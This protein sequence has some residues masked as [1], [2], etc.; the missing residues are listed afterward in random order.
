[1]TTL[2]RTPVERDRHR[3]GHATT[4]GLA[5]LLLGLLLPAA[6]AE[7]Q[8]MGGNWNQMFQPPISTRDA[9]LMQRMV[10]LDDS[11]HELVTSFVEDS[12]R[13]FQEAAEK[14][15]RMMQA[16]TEEFQ[17][18]RDPKVWQD[19]MKKFVGFEERR[20]EI[21]QDF[22]EEAKLVLTDEQLE[23]F[24]R[25]ER[26]HFRSQNLQIQGPARV[27]A[28]AVDLVVVVE[29]ME[30]DEATAESMC[31]LLDGYARESDGELRKVKKLEE[32]QRDQ[33][34]AIMEDGDW[35]GQMDEMNALFSDMRDQLVRVRDVNLRYARQVATR[36][37]TD[38]QRG[39]F[40]RS[41]NRTAYPAIFKDSYVDAAFRTV[42]ESDELNEQERETVLRLRN[43]FDRA[44]WLAN[45]RLADAQM[46]AD[47]KRT[48]QQMW[49]QGGTPEEVAEATRKKS[50]LEESYYGQLRDALRPELRKTLAPERAKE[51][52]DW[53]NSDF[54]F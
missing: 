42:L 19:M 34:L 17:E 38:Q 3:S 44:A 7:A 35:L 20:E 49:G 31:D 52:N 16:A 51:E 24:P 14:M 2:T 13:R 48:M 47:E 45:S 4:L 11:Q 8:M 53:R 39:D 30:R 1:M 15:H 29:E 5:L 27:D 21:A 36:M 18:S 23:R 40:E 43:D 12:T 6:P 9:D 10:G 22:F 54:D 26:R 37:P 46:Q 41:F 28:F 32:E 50:E 25:F 33:W